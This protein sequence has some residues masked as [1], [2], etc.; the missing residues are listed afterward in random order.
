M[1]END[2]FPSKICPEHNYRK[3][4]RIILMNKLSKA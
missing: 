4:V 3:R 2:S 1:F